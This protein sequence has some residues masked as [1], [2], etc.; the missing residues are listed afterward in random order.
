MENI[1]KKSDNCSPQKLWSKSFILVCLTYGIY[2]LAHEMAYAVLPL[3]LDKL[4]ASGTIIGLMTSLNVVA[5]MLFR[6]IVGNLSD[7][8]RKRVICICGIS[9]VIFCYLGMAWAAA[10]SSVIMLLVFRTIQGI[11]ASVSSTSIYAVLAEVS[12]QNRMTDA[13]GYFGVFFEILGGFAP[14][15]GLALCAGERFAATILCMAGIAVGA[16]VCVLLMTYEK[17][18][19]FINRSKLPKREITNEK[20]IS[21]YVEKTAI[22]AT[23]II[24]LVFISLSSVKSFLLL[25]AQQCGFGD[26]GLYFVLTAIGGIVIRLFIGPLR[27]KIGDKWLLTAGLGMIV[28]NFT[29]IS[30]LNSYIL[31]MV[32]GLLNGFGTGIYNSVLNAVAIRKTFPERYGI[33]SSTMLLGIDFGFV[34]GSLLWGIVADSFGYRILFVMATVISVISCVAGY[35]VVKENDR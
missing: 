6:P 27:R 9:S 26:V 16:V 7:K 13:Y 22:P 10:I 29:I 14:G 21:R 20:G 18:D 2:E 30:C 3:L 1:K 33:A 34:V 19:W 17:E 4:S 8:Y 23:S 32:G 12:P 11:G 5:G 35:I 15:I 24:F 31:L 28:V 25:Y